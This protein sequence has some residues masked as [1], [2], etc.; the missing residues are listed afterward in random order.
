MREEERL[1]VEGE[2]KEVI[3][4][5]IKKC[6]EDENYLPTEDEMDILKKYGLFDDLLAEEDD[7]EDDCIGI[8]VSI[9]NVQGLSLN[10]T[11]YNKGLNDASY[12]IGFISG[13]KTVNYPTKL[14]HELMLNA[15]TCENNLKVAKQTVLNN[16][17]NSI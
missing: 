2:D 10:K 6:E 3:L 13:L 5:F 1:E 4:D 16:D 7:Q 15:Q 11:E 12:Y 8:D 14:I 17:K 9:H